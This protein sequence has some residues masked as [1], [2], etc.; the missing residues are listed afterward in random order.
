MQKLHEQ[1]QASI[2]SVSGIRAS[3]AKGAARLEALCSEQDELVTELCP[4][5][6][7]MAQAKQ[8]QHECYLANKAFE[9]SQNRCPLKRAPGL[10]TPLHLLCVRNFS[11]QHRETHF[12]ISW[13]SFLKLYVRRI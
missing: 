1:Y 10:I 2:L 4:L 7:A 13:A 6:E 3:I 12:L 11:T 5:D 8:H 9:E